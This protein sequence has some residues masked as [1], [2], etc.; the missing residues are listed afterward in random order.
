[1]GII[2]L[3]VFLAML[4]GF[5]YPGIELGRSAVSRSRGRSTAAFVLLTASGGLGL[6]AVVLPFALVASSRVSAWGFVF[7]TAVGVG[8]V[9][10]LSG[11]CLKQRFRKTGKPVDGLCG[12]AFFFAAAAFPL[13]WFWLAHRLERWF[14]VNWSY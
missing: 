2:L 7:G 6:L 9:A 10:A 3:S 14:H 4:L 13:N 5:L 1:M 8:S 11:S 12:A